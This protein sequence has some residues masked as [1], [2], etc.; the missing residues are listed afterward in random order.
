MQTLLG[1]LKLEA[2]AATSI[3]WAIDAARPCGHVVLIGVYGPPYNLVNV[4]TAMNKGLTLRM[5]QCNV[6]RYM[7]HLLEHIRAGRI[8]AKGI[9]THRFPL[10]DAVEAYRTFEQ[11][12]DGCIKCV[13]VPPDAAA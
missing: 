4:G 8:D 13:L 7:P 5:G 9:I 12:K 3:T 2:G 11:R 6:K 1:K 10:E